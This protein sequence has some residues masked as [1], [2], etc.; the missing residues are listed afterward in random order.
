MNVNAP[1]APQ[2]GSTTRISTSIKALLFST[3]VSD[4]LYRVNDTEICNY[5]DSM[6]LYVGEKTL[7]T[8]LTKLEKD[9]LLLFQRFSNNLMKLNEGKCHPLIVVAK[10]KG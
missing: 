2:I 4:I 7:T 1:F 3:F 8:V 5:A 6:T 9:T 10:T